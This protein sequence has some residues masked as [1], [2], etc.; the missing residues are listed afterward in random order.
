MQ[1]TRA[2][3]DSGVPSELKVWRL[4]NIYFS[5]SPVVFFP[6]CIHAPQP[7]YCSE[8]VWLPDFFFLPLGFFFYLTFL[9]FINV[10]YREKESQR[11]DKPHS[12]FHT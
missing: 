7:E 1:H 8:E 5:H 2:Y 10:I 12:N 4:I 6:T 9:G 3:A 11:N